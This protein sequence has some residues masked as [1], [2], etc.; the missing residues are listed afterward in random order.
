MAA[1]G[2]LL[3]LKIHATLPPVTDDPRPELIKT[4][5]AIQ[6][7]LTRHG[8]RYLPE[9]LSRI[10]AQLQSND[11]A[12]IQA[13]I[14]ETTGGM[15]SLNDKVVSHSNG[16]NLD[17]FPEVAVNQRLRR[18]VEQLREQARSARNTQWFRSSHQIH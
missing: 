7:L 17:G 11:S 18:G 5:Q 1:Y 3:A 6:D 9:R 16:D 4:L 13:I 15:G 14:S 8:V 2:P 10:E 12:A